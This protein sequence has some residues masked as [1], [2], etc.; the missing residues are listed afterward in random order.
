V[1]GVAK[2]RE[3]DIGTEKGFFF[4]PYPLKW[5]N[6]SRAVIMTGTSIGNDRKIPCTPPPTPV[7][8]ALHIGTKDTSSVTKAN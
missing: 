1:L 4:K 2:C 6:T 3:G 8:P 5:G 7:T